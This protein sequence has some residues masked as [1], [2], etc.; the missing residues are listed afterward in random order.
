MKHPCRFVPSFL[1]VVTLLATSLLPCGVSVQAEMQELGETHPWYMNASVGFLDFQGDEQI[2]DSAGLFLGLGYDYSERW[3]FEGLLQVAPSLKVTPA[4]APSYTTY[5]AGLSMD[6]LFHFTRWERMDPYLAAGIGFVNYGQ[7]MPNGDQTEMQLRAGGGVMYHFN[8]EW[9]IHADYRAMLQG[10]GQSPNAN[11]IMNV[12]ISWTWAAH[13]RKDWVVKSGPDDADGDGLTDDEELELGTDVYDPD[14]DKDG[15]MDGPEVHKYKTDPMNPDTDWDGLTDGAEVLVYDTNPLAR[16]TDKG[17]V[18]DGHEVRED[19]TDPLDGS[20]DLQLFELNIQFDY[21]KADIRP[22]F[23]GDLLKIAKAILRNPKSVARIEGHADR[24][25]RSGSAYNKRLSKRRAKSVLAWLVEKGIG[26]GR[27]TAVG[28]GFERPKAP[29]DKKNGNPVNRRVEIYIRN[30]PVV[31]GAPGA[32][33]KN[34][35]IKGVPASG[36]K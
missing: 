35:P 21:K 29:N 27:L 36:T 22:E 13:L 33:A 9:A 11:S 26:K 15:L 34:Q 18:A 1:A 24:T 17:G 20:D 10:F 23:D 16:D 30:S 14:T 5:G 8:D 4:G 12:G 3:T 6:G 31:A 19:A 25:R 2:G 28:Y 7:A 32:A